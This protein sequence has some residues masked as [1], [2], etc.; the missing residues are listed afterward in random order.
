MKKAFIKMLLI[1]PGI[2]I[3]LCVLLFF[4]QEKL[5][6]FPQKLPPSYSFKFRNT[7]E[8]LIIPT[9]D[10][11]H[12]HGLL[13]KVDNPK[14]LIFYLHGNAGSLAGWGEVSETYTKL[15]YDVFILDYRGYGKSTGTINKLDQLFKDN[16]AAYLELKK[17]YSENKIVVL[18]YSIGSGLAANLASQNNPRLLILQAPYYSLADVMRHKFPFLPTFI[19]KYQISTHAYLKACIMPVVIFHG[20]QDEVIYYESS[21]KLQQEF[22]K[23]D[24]L[25]TLKQQGHNGITENPEYQKQIKRILQN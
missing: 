15:G 7:F 21:L 14:G 10:D 19:L 11:Y 17:R 18:G 3:A 16:Q 5:I 22:K 20:E 13:F 1:I 25:I 4:I 23:E 2:Y 24:T 12:L 9:S 6:F 8:E